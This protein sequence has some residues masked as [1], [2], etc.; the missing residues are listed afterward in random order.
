MINLDSTI[1]LTPPTAIEILDET[2]YC[3]VILTYNSDTEEMYKGL[4]KT[5]AY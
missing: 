3:W 5:K 1:P 2:P 4:V